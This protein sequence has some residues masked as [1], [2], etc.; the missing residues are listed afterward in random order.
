MTLRVHSFKTQ[1]SVPGT[2]RTHKDQSAA[3]V[4]LLRL[5]LLMGFIMRA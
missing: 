2:L 4:L 1:V 5:R 3:I